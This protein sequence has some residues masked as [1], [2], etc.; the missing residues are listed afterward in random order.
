VGRFAEDDLIRILTHELRPDRPHRFRRRRDLTGDRDTG[1]GDVGDAVGA[2]REE[3]MDHRLDQITLD[4]T[5]QVIEAALTPLLGVVEK[6]V[7]GR[8]YS[9]LENMLGAGADGSG[10]GFGMDPAAVASSLIT[11]ITN[12]MIA[13]RPNP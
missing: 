11:C 8:T 3:L 2:A 9:A 12:M 6:A 4:I 1:D 13:S 7:S 10:T 5:G